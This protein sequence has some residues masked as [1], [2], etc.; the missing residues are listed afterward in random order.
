MLEKIKTK[1][2]IKLF[3]AGGICLIPIVC[4]AG[5]FVFGLSLFFLIYLILDALLSS[6]GLGA[7]HP[8]LEFF[9]G[10]DSGLGVVADAFI[11]FLIDP[12]ALGIITDICTVI[13]I[14][15]MILGYICR[16]R[17]IEKEIDMNYDR[18]DKVV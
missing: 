11:T 4:W 1:P 5:L 12:N 17:F 8:V 9:I 6:W 14:V 16:K 3:I 13:G 2:Y 10:P 18:G 7:K 15:L